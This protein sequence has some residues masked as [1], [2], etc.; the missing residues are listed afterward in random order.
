MLL[1]P[2]WRTVQESDLQPEI[3]IIWDDSL[4]MTTEDARR[5]D[6]VE[7]TETVIKR[8]ELV[9]RLRET[10]FWKSFEDND[11]NRVTISSFDSPPE[12]SDPIQRAMS[13]TNM[14]DALTKTLE[15]GRNLR[16]AI[17]IGDGDWNIG[18]SPV[19]A[20]Q[21]FRLKGVPLY[22]MATGSEKR[23]PDLELAAVNAPTYGIV[24][25]NVQIPF[26]IESS[27]GRDVRTQV[28]IR[29]D[30]SKERFKDITIRA[31]STHYDSLL[32][33]IEKEGASTLSISIPVANGE[34]T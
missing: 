9:K 29:S 12:G 23:V 30:T 4:S 32:W 17:F 21:Q 18:T 34:L 24:G 31:N 13:G 11:R 25:E 28:R 3:A 1:G 2:E 14:N 26:T 22:T 15:A 27:L 8:E 6:F 33:R 5:P 7:G 16:A 19:A 10:E 20:A